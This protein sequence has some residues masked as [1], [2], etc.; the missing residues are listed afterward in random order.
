MGS[1]NGGVRFEPGGLSS[2]WARVRFS[3]RL[4]PLFNYTIQK[5]SS[6]VGELVD[7]SLGFADPSGRPLLGQ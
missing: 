1:G 3:L 4:H 7:S 5:G 2:Q 6:K